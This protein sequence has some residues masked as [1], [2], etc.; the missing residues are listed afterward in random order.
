MVVDG[1][2]KVE[3][4]KNVSHLRRDSMKERFQETTWGAA[5]VSPSSRSWL[6]IQIIRVS[7]RSPSPKCLTPS[8]G[9]GLDLLSVYNSF[10][11]EDHT[12]YGDVEREISNL[13]QIFLHHDQFLQ[14]HHVHHDQCPCPLSAFPNPSDLYLC[15]YFTIDNKTPLNVMQILA[16]QKLRNCPPDMPNAKWLWSF[17]SHLLSFNP[18]SCHDISLKIE[19][20]FKI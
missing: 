7:G 1:V 14:V 8:W 6:Q 9:E 4:P 11:W 17:V 19:Y 20:F 16:L 15:Q 5:S 3:L 13:L 2:A 12:K 10:N 18:N